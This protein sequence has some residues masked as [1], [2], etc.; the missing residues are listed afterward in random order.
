M[1]T[2]ALSP[3]QVDPILQE[4]VEKYPQP[5]DVGILNI[6]RWKSWTFQKCPLFD[7]HQG[8]KDDRTTHRASRQKI[9]IVVFIIVSILPL[10]IA[11]QLE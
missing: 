6:S 3:S 1:S 9:L 5:K 2:L 11:T 4:A 10:L 8:Y 7:V